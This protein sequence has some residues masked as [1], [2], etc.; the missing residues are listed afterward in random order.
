MGWGSG[1]RTCRHAKILANFVL[2]ETGG[3]KRSWA[4]MQIL[5]NIVW[6]GGVGVWCGKSKERTV[7]N[8]YLVW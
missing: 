1:N 3:V 8:I 6:G 4:D 2:G 5:A 7:S